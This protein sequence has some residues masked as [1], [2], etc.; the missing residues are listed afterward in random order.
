[1]AA[2]HLKSEQL[3]GDGQN[4]RRLHLAMWKHAGG[5]L[6]PADGKKLPPVYPILDSE[7][8]EALNQTAGS[9]RQE[10]KQQQRKIFTVDQDYNKT[11]ENKEKSMEV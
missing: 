1:M 3:P 7:N 8:R 4:D 6:F 10:K 2:H 11:I 5:S 9:Q